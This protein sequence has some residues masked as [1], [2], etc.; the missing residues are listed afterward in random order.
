MKSMTFFQ[1]VILLAL[2]LGA[3]VSFAGFKEGGG[4]IG[5]V[6]KC[7]WLSIDGSEQYQVVLYDTKDENQAARYL[8]SVAATKNGKETVSMVSG[9]YDLSTAHFTS[10]NQGEMEI[11]LQV[12]EGVVE[13]AFVSGAKAPMTDGLVRYVPC[14]IKGVSS[15]VIRR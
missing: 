14:Q 11:D 6:A 12:N 8:A 3:S 7:D 4:V 13:A 15:D 1:V 9:S 10:T 5:P 2:Q